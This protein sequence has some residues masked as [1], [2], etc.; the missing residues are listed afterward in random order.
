M[1]GDVRK[2]ESVRQAVE[3]NDVVYHLAG[4]TKSLNRSEQRLVNEAGVHNVAKSCASLASP[5]V[6]IVVSSL[7]AAG[8][9][10]AER[11]RVEE[12]PASPVSVYGRS[13]LAGEAAAA[14]FADRVP[15]TIVRPPIVFGAGDRD[16]FLMFASIARW[17]VHLTPTLLNR[18]YSLIH[19]EDLIAALI[20]LAERGKRIT[21]GRSRV[22]IYF[23]ADDE[24]PTC[25]E[26]GQMIGKALG[27][28]RILVVRNL[29]I[30]VYAAAA[31]NELVSRVRQRPH[32]FSFD[33]AREAVA[34]SWTSSTTAIKRD[35]GFR[36][37]SSL[38]ERLEQTTQW[39]L[40]HGWLR[41][42]RG[43]RASRGM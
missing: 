34:G 38:V 19:A 24:T 31:V 15:T 11:P 26:L 8:P 3:G 21:A 36:P 10:T 12:D 23:V 28:S 40:D 42:P 9:S 22:G 5:P 1:F 30:S 16:G 37:A 27:R 14:K 41:S 6:L 33:K 4:V 7:A 2:P 17:G 43:D 32:I 39:Y 35:V 25:A 13:K 20:A 18:R 29:S